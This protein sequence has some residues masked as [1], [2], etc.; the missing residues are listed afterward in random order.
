MVV[1]RFIACAPVCA[2]VLAKR[3]QRRCVSDSSSSAVVGRNGGGGELRH[4]VAGK[5]AALELRLLLSL[6]PPFAGAL[7]LAGSSLAGREG[8]GPFIAKNRWFNV[9]IFFL[10]A[11]KLLPETNHFLPPP[12]FLFLQ[13]D[14]HYLPARIYTYIYF[15]FDRSKMEQVLGATRCREPSRKPDRSTASWRRV[16]AKRGRSPGADSQD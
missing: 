15:V 2:C 6:E 7:C 10:S 4:N 12:F 11:W 9:F 1:G 5:G 3:Q 8:H 13:V 16:R 14:L